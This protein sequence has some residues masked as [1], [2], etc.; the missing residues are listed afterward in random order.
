VDGRLRWFSLLSVE[1]LLFFSPPRPANMENEVITR[2]LGPLFAARTK[3]SST[4][5]SSSSLTFEIEARSRAFVI[6][7]SLPRFL[8]PSPSSSGW[9]PIHPSFLLLSEAMF[10]SSLIVC[11]LQ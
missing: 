6:V 7:V 5:P 9:P 3:P 4:I 8:F 10:F 1:R 11:S 2:N